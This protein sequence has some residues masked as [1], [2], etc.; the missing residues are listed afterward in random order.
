VSWSAAHL[1]VCLSSLS[2]RLSTSRFRFV[3]R[4]H[5][6]LWLKSAAQIRRTMRARVSSV[7]SLRQSKAAPGRGSDHFL[8]SIYHESDTCR[9]SSSGGG[10]SRAQ[11]EI[12]IWTRILIIAND[13]SGPWTRVFNIDHS[14]YRTA[15]LVGS[16]TAVE[17]LERRP[18]PAAVASRPCS[19]RWPGT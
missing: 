12:D 8:W 18:P 19:L 5:V 6:P 9:F 11:I 17:G 2:T 4:G 16:A 14:F 13:S 10:A 15:P 7:S 1:Q 3:H